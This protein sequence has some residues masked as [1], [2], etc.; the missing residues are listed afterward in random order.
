M[1]VAI[2]T[3]RQAHDPDAAD[4]RR[5]REQRRPRCAWMPVGH[6]QWTGCYDVTASEPRRFKIAACKSVSAKS[7]PLYNSGRLRTLARA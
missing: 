6:M 3:A 4:R 7:L 2:T 1:A 5:R